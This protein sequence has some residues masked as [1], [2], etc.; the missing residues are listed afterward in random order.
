VLALS[1]RTSP[2]LSRATGTF[3]DLAEADVR[4]KKGTASA[5]SRLVRYHAHSGPTPIGLRIVPLN[6]YGT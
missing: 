4:S 3:R 5:Q 2:M 6:Q 1:R